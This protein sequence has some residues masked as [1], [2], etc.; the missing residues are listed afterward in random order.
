LPNNAA[1][2]PQQQFRSGL[3]AGAGNKPSRYSPSLTFLP[4]PVEALTAG[5]G[6][7]E[8]DLSP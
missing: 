5:T 1:F 6:D 4:P 2:P 7:T 8:I 3:P